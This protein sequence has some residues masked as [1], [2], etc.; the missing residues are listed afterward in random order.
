SGLWE[1]A[2]GPPELLPS[3]L[4]TPR[5]QLLV[6]RLARWE[7]LSARD[8]LCTARVLISLTSQRRALELLWPPAIPDGRAPADVAGLAVIAF[9]AAHHLGWGSRKRLI[10]GLT[11][12]VAATPPD[13]L[14]RFSAGL[15]LAGLAGAGG[16]APTLS[17]LHRDLVA[18]RS[19]LRPADWLR[20]SAR[21]YALEAKLLGP[22]DPA[23][24]AAAIGE[25]EARLAEV[26]P[27]DDDDRLLAAEAIRRVTDRRCLVAQLS[28]H[29]DDALAAAERAVEL[30]PWDSKAWLLRGGVLLAA[31]RPANALTAFQRSARL[32]PLFTDRAWFMHGQALERLERHKEAVDSYLMAMRADATAAAP[33]AALGRCARRL[34]LPPLAD[35][36]D[37]AAAALAGLGLR[38][39]TLGARG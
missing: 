36:A 9:A 6:E 28:G 1:Y 22:R 38:P 7:A 21:V 32:G 14:A 37:R 26:V 10:D 39:A 2:D 30:D 5:W 18:A 34:H 33:V 31:G 29:L 20:L 23:A 16:S 24:A 27:E 3:E 19:A 4:R 11:A 13:A 8:R 17:T 35:L 15:L 25:A 12:L